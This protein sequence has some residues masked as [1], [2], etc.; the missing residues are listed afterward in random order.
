MSAHSPDI[1]HERALIL[2]TL[3]A[4]VTALGNVIGRNTEVVL[5]DLEHPEKSVLAI[6]NGHVTGR[7]LG[8]P[9]LDVPA[10]DRGLQALINETT[11]ANDNVPKVIPDYPTRGKQG[12]T[13]RSATALY[14]DSNGQAFA[15]LCINTDNSELLAARRCLDNLL[16]SPDSPPPA[17]EE[18]ADMAQLMA[19]IIAD[20]LSE[21]NGDLRLSRKQ[22]KL[23]A[24]RKMQERGMFIVKGGIEKA[25]TALGVT[26]YTIYNYLDEIRDGQQPGSPS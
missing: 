20:S 21:L 13:L 12:Q 25:A 22:A 14:R 7:V 6:T 3:H 23:A 2:Q 4:A 19:E 18:S 8:S 11:P 26:R 9:V 5:H 16:N 15:A 10:Q 1:A 17:A 24:V